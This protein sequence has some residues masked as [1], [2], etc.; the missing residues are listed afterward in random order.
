MSPPSSWARRTG[1]AALANGER[2]ARHDPVLQV[3]VLER[4]VAERAGSGDPRVVDE[5]VDAAEGQHGGVHGL[6]HRG[7]VGHVGD[8]A[9]RTV[10]TAELG[11]D[12][13]DLRLVEVGDDDVGPLGGERPGG[14][15]P[16]AGG[17]TRD[18]GDPAGERL[19][20]RSP[21]Q[22]QLLE[23]PVLHGEL[24]GLVDRRVGR[25]AL[26]A[27][28]DVDG[29]DVE[30]TGHPRRLLVRA[31]R[32]HPD[33]RHEDDGRRGAAHRGGVR[34]G[35]P[36]VVGAVLLAVLLLEGAQPRDDLVERGV[37]R[38][39][40]QQR[41]HLGAQEVVRA[42]GPEVD[43][44][45]GLGAREEVE[46]RIRVGVVADLAAVARRDAAQV[47]EEGGGAAAAFVGLGQR[48]TARV[49]R[50]ERLVDG[51]LRHV[52]GRLAD[53]PQASFLDL[54]A[55][56]P[57]RGQP[58]TAEDGA[59]DP[60]L[61]G[62]LPHRPAQLPARPLPRHPRHRA[63]PDLL[64]QLLAV[65]GAGQGDDAVGMQ[66][67]DVRVLDQRVH[68]GVDRRGGTAGPVAAVGEQPDHLVLVLDAAVDPVQA[69]QP[70][71]LE[72]RET[73]G[74]EGAEVAAGALDV[75][76][77]HGL[78]AG[79]AGD[80]HLGRGVAAAV[81]RHGGVRPESVAAVQQCADLVGEQG[82]VRHG[83]AILPQGRR[84][85]GMRRRASLVVRQWFR[86]VQVWGRGG[87]RSRSGARRSA[88]RPRESP[89]RG[90]C[91]RTGRR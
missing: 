62:Q 13:A 18:D 8:D 71:S 22:L 41:P 17:G 57:P 19:G 11:G 47:R 76:Q 52:C 25:D 60:L 64:D 10:R 82:G 21:L 27:A 4:R 59:D 28:H 51:P 30:L 46:H 86:P 78:A 35:V 75:E 54:L 1:S 83:G 14:R 80:G 68:R 42:A 7:L 31:E 67:V 33:S 38:G 56:R 73:L 87:R 63:A 32:E 50:S 16:D 61:A 34:R 69:H 36:V 37:R 20:L 85:A 9:G 70:V 48:G 91:S 5:Q 55:R 49:D 79:R 53:D 74:G 3:P 2:A 66:V 23:D 43:E 77:L 26:G 88:R 15:E 24:V 40:E 89:P 72:H 65:G 84:S 45:V 29:V 39:V 81:V 44:L 12:L 58:V 6:G 90:C